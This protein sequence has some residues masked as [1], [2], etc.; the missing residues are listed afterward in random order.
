MAETL[1]LQV[2]TPKGLHIDEDVLSV[3]APSVV[4]EFGAL[5]NHLPM[6]AAIKPGVVQYEI[7]SKKYA[8]AIGGG[9]A[10]AAGDH[11]LLLADAFAQPEP[12]ERTELEKEL[13]E[14]NRELDEVGDDAKTD[15][16]HLERRVAWA[17]ARIDAIDVASKL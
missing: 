8:L 11:V 12:S 16:A 10:E 14:A 17:Q 4:G 13:A 9:Y 6:L 2:A 3:T 7:S 1:K 15:F 5:P